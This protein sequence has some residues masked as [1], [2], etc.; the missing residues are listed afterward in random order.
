MVGVIN[1][2]FYK[3][4]NYGVIRNVKSLLRDANFHKCSYKL[5]DDSLTRISTH[6][7][8]DLQFIGTTRFDLTI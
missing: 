6:Y 7:T 5:Q 4:D 8:T 1:K 3:F 2:V